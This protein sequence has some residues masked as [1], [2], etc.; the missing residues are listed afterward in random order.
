MILILDNIRSNH[1]VGSL[2]RTAD[3]A[4][5]E[6]LYLCGYTPG[7]VDRFGR[8]N[9]ALAKVALGAEQRLSWEHSQDIEMLLDN[10]RASGYTIYGLEQDARAVSLFDRSVCARNI[11]KIALI[12]GNEVD[13]I[14]EGALA[15]CDVIVEIPM[16][17]TKESLNVSVACGIAAYT[18]INT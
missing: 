14:A 18:L 1:N 9:S 8:E 12:V 10:V 7:P 17:G 2:F 4:G 13:G 3:A 11:E 5:V 15:R 6:R 16:H